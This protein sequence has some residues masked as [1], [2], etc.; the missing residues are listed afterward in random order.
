MLRLKNA[1]LG[2]QVKVLALFCVWCECVCGESEG[3][4]FCE[5]LEVLVVLLLPTLFHC[6]VS[7]IASTSREDL[8]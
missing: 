4:S 1:V 2:I 7:L 5:M 6:E 8:I 3:E